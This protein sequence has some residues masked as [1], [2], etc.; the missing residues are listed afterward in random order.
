MTR[1]T[2]LGFKRKHLQAGFDDE[3]GQNKDGKLAENAPTA[4]DEVV[5]AE[6][7][8]KKRKRSKNKSKGPGVQ[9]DEVKEGKEAD[10][11]IESNS[12]AEVKDGKAEGQPLS[13]RK[14]YKK[15]KL[16]GME[17]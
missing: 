7:L 11:S 9:V 5:N 10:G 6:P 16:K 2:N 1:Y 17:I 3:E 12:N 15:K 13:N 14:L 4:T 8:K